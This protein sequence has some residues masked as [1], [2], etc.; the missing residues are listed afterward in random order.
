MNFE[1][2]L[3]RFAMFMSG[4]KK[5]DGYKG[6]VTTTDQFHSGRQGWTIKKMSMHFT[7]WDFPESIT[8]IVDEL[9]V[10]GIIMNS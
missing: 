10:E 4:H 7:L 6:D 8:N 9:L 1:F 5:N 2:R 3:N